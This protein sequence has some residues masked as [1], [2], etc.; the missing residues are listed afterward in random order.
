MLVNFRPRAFVDPEIM[1]PRFAQRGLIQLQLLV[2]R[3]V[4]AP[5]L[6]HK[7]V[8]HNPSGFNQLGQRFLVARGEAGEID[9]QR[10]W[11]KA[12]RHLVKF[13]GVGK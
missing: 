3:Q 13:I 2:K 1:Q 10:C 6:L 12:R 8:V 7:E 9:F 5:E 11:R 4:A